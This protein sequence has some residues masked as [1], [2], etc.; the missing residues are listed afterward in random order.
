M[1]NHQRF[2][3]F[4][5]GNRKKAEPVL[6]RSLAD[7]SGPVAG[8][9]WEIDARTHRKTDVTLATEKHVIAV[10]PGEN[11]FLM[12]LENFLDAYGKK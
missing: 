1:D 7:F 10:Q 3:L 2:R 4:G 6:V 5:Y 8:Y 11:A 9:A 12:E